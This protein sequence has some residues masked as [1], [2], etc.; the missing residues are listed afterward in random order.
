MA[1]SIEREIQETLTKLTGGLRCAVLV[2]EARAELSAE[3]LSRLSPEL[4]KAWSGL[5]AAARRLE[6]SE[7]RRGEITLRNELGE[8]ATTSVSHTREGEIPVVFIAAVADHRS[9]GIDVELSSRA[10][11]DAVA[12]RFISPDDDRFGLAPLQIWVI[13]EALFKANP[14]NESTTLPQYR[15]TDFDSKSGLGI[16]RI[17]HRELRFACLRLDQWIVAVAVS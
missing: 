4:Q 1:A 12:R 14:E 17:G 7:A 2:R 5:K 8:N 10:V 9:V 13:K 6:W 16:A 3:E 15:L 11:T